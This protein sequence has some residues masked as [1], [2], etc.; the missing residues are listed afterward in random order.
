MQFNWNSKHFKSKS[1]Y[2]SCFKAIVPFV[3]FFISFAMMSQPVFS[4]EVEKVLY[5]AIQAEDKNRIDSLLKEGVDIN[6]G[7]Y[8][9]RVT[10]DKNRE[11]FQY[12]LDLGAD[13]NLPQEGPAMSHEDRQDTGKKTPLCLVVANF[14]SSKREMDAIK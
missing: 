7:N 11:M 5:K 8:L 6:Q 4:Y 3:G 12:L 10:L 13:I 1:P 14:L 2:K 9:N